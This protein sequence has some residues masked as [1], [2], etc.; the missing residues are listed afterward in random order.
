M[1]NSHACL[2]CSQLAAAATLSTALALNLV[3]PAPVQ[4]GKQIQTHL[5]QLQAA[6]AS[7]VTN[8]FALNAASGNASTNGSNSAGY[9]ANPSAAATTDGSFWSTPL[10]TVLMLA[11]IATLP[12][13]FLFTPITLPVSMLVAASQTDTQSSFSTLQFLILTAVGFLTGPLGLASLLIKP[14]PTTAAALSSRAM[15]SARAAAVKESTAPQTTPIVASTATSPTVKSNAS[16]APTGDFVVDTLTTVGRAVATV[17]GWA[18]APIWYAAFPITT[19][20]WDVG[21]SQLF[22]NFPRLQGIPFFAMFPSSW[23]VPFQ[24][25]DILLP[26]ATSPKAGPWT[27]AAMP[28]ASREAATG[29]QAVPTDAPTAPTQRRGKAVQ[30]STPQPT[31]KKT[32]NSMRSASATGAAQSS[33]SPKPASARRT[34][35]AAH[36]THR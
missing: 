12:I 10:G 30:G 35:L 14:S 28:T 25:A 24:L 1:D 34:P 3:T 23:F 29:Q 36:G 15:G 21:V 31:S 19:T 32:A 7:A 26:I 8:S 5:V 22:P 20:I 13:W 6:T 9:Q 16:V 4:I 33:D 11:D 18:L 17:A 27:G 2:R